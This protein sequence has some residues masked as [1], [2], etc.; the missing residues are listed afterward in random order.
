MSERA[1]NGF[2]LATRLGYD[3]GCDRR[4][5]IIVKA[6]RNCWFSKCAFASLVSLIFSASSRP[7]EN[8]AW[9]ESYGAQASTALSQARTS[10][11][12]GDPE[13]A[14]RIL[15]GYLSAHPKEFSA[16]LVLGQ[17][18]A[19]AGQTDQAEGE[20]QTVIKESP[21]NYVALAALGELYY[22]ANQWERAEPYLAR[23]AKSG[24]D[25]P[26]IRIEWSVD[27]RSMDFGSKFDANQLFAG[28]M[29]ID[30]V[31]GAVNISLQYRPD[32]YGR[33]HG[34]GG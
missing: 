4:A 26:Q 8:R 24:R 9:Q 33:R 18:Y 3:E 30:N 15:S 13:E 21:N 5:A 19:M 7:L 16:R 14:I 25:A 23:A 31:S 32:G 29:F 11:A 10:L 1:E 20:F 6:R 22:H 34:L 12:H 2:R 28:D 17:A 27:T